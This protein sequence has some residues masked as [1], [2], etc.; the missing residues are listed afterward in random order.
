M[1]DE[2]LSQIVNACECRIINLQNTDQAGFYC[3]L[4]FKDISRKLAYS[5]DGDPV[6]Q[7]LVDYLG[8][9]PPIYTRDFQI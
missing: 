7:E 6:A 8:D 2:L 9:S 3:V 5:S 1:K 4:Y